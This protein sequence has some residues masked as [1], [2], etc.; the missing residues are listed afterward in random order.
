MTQLTDN[1]IRH[2]ATNETFTI[3]WAR[4]YYYEKYIIIPAKDLCMFAI[5]PDKVYKIKFNE[6]NINDL[7]KFHSVSCSRHEEEHKYQPYVYLKKITP[8]E[9]S[10]L[11]QQY[12]E[13]YPDTG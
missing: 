1:Y 5:H 6:Q 3:R 9:A 7:V 4:H 8:L 2:L 11:I 12:H 10:E 13:T